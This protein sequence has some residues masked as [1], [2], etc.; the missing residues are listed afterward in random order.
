MNCP[1]CGEERSKI[2]SCLDESLATSHFVRHIA[3]HME[4]IAFGVV[5]RAY[6]DWSYDET[7][8]EV[9]RLNSPKEAGFKCPIP[10]F[11]APSFQ[12]QYPLK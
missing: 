4:E 5:T 12:T 3:R 10:V 2:D 1:F 11:T 7:S 8:S 9:T 6:E